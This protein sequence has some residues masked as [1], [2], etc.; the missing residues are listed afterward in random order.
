[1]E[2]GISKMVELN[3]GNP[4]K[5]TMQEY[6]GLCGCPFPMSGDSLDKCRFPHGRTLRQQKRDCKRSIEV[7]NDYCAK[8]ERA[9]TEYAQLVATG[10][11]IP[12][13][14]IEQMIDRANGHPDN[15][16]TQAARRICQKRGI[17]WHRN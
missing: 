14:R 1:M 7:S 13:S 12:K 6:Y 16:S 9:R 10:V 5:M 3:A 17:D 4:V 15:E 11:I 2:S 8:R